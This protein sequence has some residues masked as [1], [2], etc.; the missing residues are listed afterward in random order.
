[1]KFWKGIFVAITI[2]TAILIMAFLLM[3]VVTKCMI[4]SEHIFICPL[5]FVGGYGV[6][7]FGLAFY[8]LWKAMKRAPD[9]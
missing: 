7:C 6:Y 2:E 4:T 3:F 5:V 9:K 8:E 1:M